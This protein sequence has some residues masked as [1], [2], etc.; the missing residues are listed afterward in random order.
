[1]THLVMHYY[2]QQRL[3]KWGACP[4]RGPVHIYYGLTQLATFFFALERNMKLFVIG[5]KIKKLMFQMKLFFFK[6]FRNYN[7]DCVDKRGIA[8]KKSLETTKAIR[9]VQK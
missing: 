2:I 3:I 1:M 7:F 5:L 6:L 9:D 8:A 4:T